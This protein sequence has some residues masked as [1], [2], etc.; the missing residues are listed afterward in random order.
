MKD[1]NKNN[2]STSDLMIGMC[3]GLAFDRNDSDDDNK[4][5][6]DTKK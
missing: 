4:D 3:I 2:K 1:N 5:N 6:T